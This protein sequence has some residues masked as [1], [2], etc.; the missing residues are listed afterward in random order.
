MKLFSLSLVSIAVFTIA[1][2]AIAVECNNRQEV[3]SACADITTRC[4]DQ[5]AQ[6]GCPVLANCLDKTGEYANIIS[7]S[8]GDLDIDLIGKHCTDAAPNA[9]LDCV[10]T[11]ACVWNATLQRCETAG[12][13]CSR[14]STTAYKVTTQNCVQGS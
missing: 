13:P 2:I 3:E 6:S 1:G 14:T 10:L 11:Y 7:T 4:E 8:C 5:T 9:P 12:M